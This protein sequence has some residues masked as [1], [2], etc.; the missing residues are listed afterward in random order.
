MTLALARAPW[1]SRT[2]IRL[3]DFAQRVVTISTITATTMLAAERVFG[4]PELVEEIFDHLLVDDAY[5]VGLVSPTA[6][7]CAVAR[8][9]ANARDY[10]QTRAIFN[11]FESLCLDEAER[12]SKVRHDALF[13]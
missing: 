4:I 11:Y 1:G 13:L 8:L 7:G 6:F 3:L 5:C 10:G 2:A 9:R 12:R